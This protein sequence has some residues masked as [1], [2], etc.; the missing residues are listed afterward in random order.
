MK[1]HRSNIH[2]VKLQVVCMKEIFMSS[3][4]KNRRVAA[5]MW[6]GGRERGEETP[7]GQAA[8]RAHPR[9]TATRMYTFPS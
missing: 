8:A 2:V 9:L 7:G 3:K 1:S 4:C 5:S 6:G